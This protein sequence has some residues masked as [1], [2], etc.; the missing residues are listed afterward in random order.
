MS[1][2]RQ[3]GA[4]PGRPVQPGTK[5]DDPY[6]KVADWLRDPKKSGVTTREAVQYDRRVDYFKGSKL[7]DALISPKYAANKGFPAV[8]TKEQAIALA[9]QLIKSHYF[10]RSQRVFISARRWEL[11]VHPGTFEEDGLYTWMY[12]GSKTRLYVLSGLTLLGALMLCMI[13]IWPIWMK[14]ALWWCSVTFLT[15]FSALCIVRLM[16]FCLMFAVGFRGIWLFPNLFDDNQT[17]AGS[18]MPI[19]GRAE[20]V[21]VAD[22]YDSDDDDLRRVRTKKKD[23]GDAAGAAAGK[24]GAKKRPEE[25]PAFQFGLVNAAL[26][27]GVGLVC[28]W[29][30]GF[31]DGENV[32]D[33]VAKHEDLTYYFPT[34]A[35]PENATEAKVDAD[36]NPVEGDERDPFAAPSDDDAKF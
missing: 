33:F 5:P 18:F 2:V 25:E 28:C 19:M 13:Q 11:E 22:E 16:L 17:F 36:G 34:I 24:G 6:I 14:I 3:R 7:V 10:H 23:D 26:L 1:A 31:F 21:V 27:F 30:M 29:N 32:P 12:E 20:P 15:T 35:P 9:N 4:A 8:S